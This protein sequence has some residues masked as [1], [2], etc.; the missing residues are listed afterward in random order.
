M[1]GGGAPGLAGVI[2]EA[3][4]RLL[5]PRMFAA[6]AMIAGIGVAA[7]ALAVVPNVPGFAHAAGILDSVAPIWDQIYAYA[8]FVGFLL[9]G[10]L[11]WVLMQISPDPAAPTSA[12]KAAISPPDPA[13]HKGQ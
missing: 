4:Y 10:G 3:G 13:T 2:Q 6:L 1:G 7:F 8:W 12:Q 5:I 9:G 11:Y